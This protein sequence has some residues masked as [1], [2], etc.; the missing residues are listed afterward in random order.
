MMTEGLH[1]R[2]ATHIEMQSEP[3]KM[4]KKKVES[5]RVKEKDVTPNH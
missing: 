4:R 1:L 2:K 3:D 5:G